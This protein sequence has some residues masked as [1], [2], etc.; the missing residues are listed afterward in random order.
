MA[1][2]WMAMA[3]L[4]TDT[5]LASPSPPDLCVQHWTS[6]QGRAD[7]Q[8]SSNESMTRRHLCSQDPNPSFTSLPPVV[9]YLTAY[10]TF[11]T[12]KWRWNICLRQ[13]RWLCVNIITITKFPA[14]VCAHNITESYEH[15]TAIST[16]KIH[17]NP[18][19]C[20]HVWSIHVANDR[21]PCPLHFL[22]PSR[23]YLV[24]NTETLSEVDG[25]VW[26][27]GKAKYWSW[28]CPSLKMAP[29]SRR[30]D[31]DH[32]SCNRWLCLP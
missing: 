2:L 23:T 19:E 28:S 17:L 20:T 26:E 14:S 3:S 29:C 8:C 16:L 10:A 6:T 18:C 13:S 22:L 15:F 27:T 7:T 21:V 12:G 31:G 5:S 1:S 24:L 11:R 25:K 30:R 32:S 4:W 9:S